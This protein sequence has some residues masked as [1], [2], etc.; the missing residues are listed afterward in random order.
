MGATQIALRALFALIVTCPFARA[1]QV[2]I[3]I[4]GGTLRAELAMPVG[5][6]RGAAVVALHGCGGPYPARDG[7]WRDT[8]TAAGHVVLLPDSFGSRGL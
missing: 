5:P 1:A 7:Q 6:S 2:E 3:P 4:E 8:L